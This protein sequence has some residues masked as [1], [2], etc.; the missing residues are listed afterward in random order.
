MRVAEVLSAAPASILAGMRALLDQG[1][2]LLDSWRDMY[3]DLVQG[4]L[5]NLLLALLAHF[6]VFAG[7][8]SPDSLPPV[9][10]G[11][12]AANLLYPATP[13]QP[14]SPA[15]GLAHVSRA[16][17]SALSPSGRG[18]FSP[19]NATIGTP[20]GAGPSY[21]VTS[22]PAPPGAVLLL[23]C[24]ATHVE[25]SVLPFCM[26]QLAE[27][28]PGSGGGGGGDQP[29]PFVAG[30]LARRIAAT[31]SALLSAY[32][33]AHGRKLSLMVRRSVESTNWLLCKVRRA[34]LSQANLPRR[35]VARRELLF[36]PVYTANVYCFA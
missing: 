31:A 11:S 28:F 27:R 14:G 1:G 30:E 21:V 24:L 36:P 18:L 7:V 10:Y 35:R 5:Q 25:A 29:P 2:R 8:A 16:S 34:A 15:S 13:R 12:F 6:R 26:E 20:D 9:H 22:E 19:L 3:V 17:S 33:E 32:V 4:S 23:A